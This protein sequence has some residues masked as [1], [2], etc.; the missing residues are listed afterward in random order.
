MVQAQ[1]LWDGA[2]IQQL[3]REHKITRARYCYEEAETD[4][5]HWLGGLEETDRP[6]G[7][8]ESR[9]EHMAKLAMNETILYALDFDRFKARFGSAAQWLSD[10]EI[11]YTLHE[12][13]AHSKFIP[14]NARAESEQWLKTHPEPEHQVRKRDT[15]Q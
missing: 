9:A 15:S 7:K 14:E 4:Y 11:L 8:Q 12:W 1:K 6:W 3:F 13:R 2:R 10:E 5:C